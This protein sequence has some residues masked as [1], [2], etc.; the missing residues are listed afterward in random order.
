MPKPHHVI[1]RLS[2]VGLRPMTINRGSFLGRPNRHVVTLPVYRAT[3]DI[4]SIASAFTAFC[5]S[6]YTS[7]RIRSQILPPLDSI[8]Q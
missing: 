4:C 7:G 3:T 6:G 1:V 5:G 8:K 2:S